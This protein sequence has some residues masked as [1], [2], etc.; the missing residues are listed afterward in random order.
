MNAWRQVTRGKV[1]Y[2][3]Y[4][5]G[6]SSA[7]YSLKN[8]QDDLIRQFEPV[9]LKQIHSNIIVDIDVQ[10]ERTGDG[11]ISTEKRN[12]GL[13]IADC[14]PVYLFTPQ[15]TCII[16]CGWR[17]IIGGIAKGASNLLKEFHYVLGASIGPCCYEVKHD[18]V[19]QFTPDHQNALQQRQGRHYLDL[20]AAVV[21]DL[22]KENL[23]ASLDFCTKCH[24][25]YFYSHR[26]GDSERNYALIAHNQTVD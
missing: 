6:N 20:K 24:P 17:G 11:L 7:I 19:N 15:R 3:Q 1:S 12:I 18:V 16:H 23:L 13:K 10:E 2:F 4:S 26:R 14:L 9:F 5:W 8:G 25:E 21:N 22:G